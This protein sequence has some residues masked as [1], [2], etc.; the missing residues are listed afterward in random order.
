MHVPIALNVVGELILITRDGYKTKVGS[1]SPYE[2]A[3]IY[4]GE[5]AIINQVLPHCYDVT[6]R[7]GGYRVMLKRYEF[8][9]RWE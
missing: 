6:M 5:F 8:K 3:H 9:F 1:P 2:V 4:A 7:N